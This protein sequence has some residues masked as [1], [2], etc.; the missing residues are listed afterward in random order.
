M[1]EFRFERKKENISDYIKTTMFKDNFAHKFLI[2]ALIICLIIVAVSGIVMYLTVKKPSMLI[3]TVVGVLL[4]AA[5][6]LFLHFFIKNLTDKLSR[7]N[8]EEEGVTIAI[9]E[10]N[11]LLIRNNS[12]CGKLEWTDI[13][14][15]LESETGF[16][17]T[18]KEGALIILGKNSLHSGSY[19]EAEQ[20]LRAKK[21][22]LK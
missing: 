9:S 15:I 18:E 17:L 12:P 10:N 11:I 20:I 8:P 5:Y 13:T 2:G 3:I 4:A 6:P 22:A 14:E 1:T 19:E 16:F 7:A 21:A